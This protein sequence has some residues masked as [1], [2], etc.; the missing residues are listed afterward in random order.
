M[1]DS[2]IG[3]GTGKTGPRGK[4]R[5]GMSIYGVHDLIGNVAEW[6][7]TVDC[8]Y[9]AAPQIDPAG[10]SQ[11]SMKVVGGSFLNP[12]EYLRAAIG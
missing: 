9:R 2:G 4:S 5:A 1:N 7:L 12:E 8:E 6:T 10:P 3:C 11:G